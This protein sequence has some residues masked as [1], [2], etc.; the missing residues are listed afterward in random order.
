MSNSPL[1]RK[2]EVSDEK[3]QPKI[4]AEGGQRPPFDIRALGRASLHLSREAVAPI[5]AWVA[6]KV[7]RG[8]VRVKDGA[9][10]I[11]EEKLGRVAR[12]VP[13]HL[14]VAAWIKNVGAVLAHASAT[15]DQDV[16][17]GNALVAEIEPHLWSEAEAQATAELADK[18]PEAVVTVQDAPAIVLLEPEPA[19]DDPLAS[20][21][22]DLS[23]TPKAANRTRK[24][25]INTG[26]PAVPPE[27]PGPLA[28]GAIQVT[29][30]LIGWASA[31]ITLPYGLAYA[32]WLY[33][34]K[35][36]DL[37]KIGAEE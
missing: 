5:H 12:F 11:P 16:K 17:R 27:P 28:T 6:R 33:F 36:Q 24:A 22:D 37:R 10:R 20:I 3:P 26:G 34:A 32:L 18:P 23:G 21:R 4:W 29:G 30:Y 35:L 2:P 9:G 7:R 31:I 25:Q 15:A 13:S 14:R 8:A 19:Q 1:R